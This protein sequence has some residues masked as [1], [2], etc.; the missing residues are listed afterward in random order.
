MSCSSAQAGRAKET[1]KA[2]PHGSRFTRGQGAIGKEDWPARTTL[3]RGTTERAGEDNLRLGD[4]ATEGTSDKE[5][6]QHPRSVDLRSLLLLCHPHETG[7]GAGEDVFIA[8]DGI[9]GR[10]AA[11]PPRLADDL[12]FAAA[13]YRSALKAGIKEHGEFREPVPAIA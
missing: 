1:A 12:R 7:E 6:A 8:L 2:R 3:S 13:I 4:P 9:R 10:Q 11:V 5:K